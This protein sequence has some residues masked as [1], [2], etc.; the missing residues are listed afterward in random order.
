MDNTFVND[1]MEN[2]VQRVLVD[3]YESLDLILASVLAD[4][5]TIQVLQI[6]ESL[7]DA[8]SH[9]W[10]ELMMSFYGRKD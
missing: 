6:R 10:D 3:V 7:N 5:Q 2:G 8:L 9:N 4:R 1:A